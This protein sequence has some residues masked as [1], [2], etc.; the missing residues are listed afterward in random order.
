[1]ENN[2]IFSETSTVTVQIMKL[3]GKK[4]TASLISQLDHRWPFDLFYNF[5][6]NLIFGY[7]K[8]KVASDRIGMMVIA[9]E[10][11]RLVKFNT[12]R[13][14]EIANIDEKTSWANILYLLNL[15]VILND[16]TIRDRR[17]QK[18]YSEDEQEPM[19]DFI[20]NNEKIKIFEVRDRVRSFL[21]ELSNHQIFI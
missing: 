7:V 17:T 11:D 6:G 15:K 13:L 12:I 19:L 14:K 18:E 16:E 4:I 10:N 3:D 21:S 2:I 20:D 5:T 9:K 1:M 8:M